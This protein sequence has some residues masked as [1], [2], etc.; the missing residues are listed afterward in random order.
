MNFANVKK[1][2]S[3]TGSSMGKSEYIP[4]S[5]GA[6]STDCDSVAISSSRIDRND[7]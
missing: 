3:S 2:T 7:L 5:R 1:R 4:Q 6:Q